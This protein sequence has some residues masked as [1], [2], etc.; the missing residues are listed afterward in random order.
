M[1]GR[2]EDCDYKLEHPSVSRMHALLAYDKKHGLTITDLGTAQG[3]FVKGERCRPYM[4]LSIKGG[5]T[6]TFGASNREHKIKLDRTKLI[7]R[8]QEK[9]R[10]LEAELA[11]TE[12]KSDDALEEELKAE[13]EREARPSQTVFV[14]NLNFETGEASIR[15]LFEGAGEIEE[16]RMPRH[17]DG[18]NV[19][20]SKG[21]C[22]VKFKNAE[23]AAKAVRAYNGDE[24]DDRSIK[25]TIAED[26]DNR[27]A[28]PAWLVN[29]RTGGK[30]KGGKGGKGKGGDSGTDFGRHGHEHRGSRRE[31]RRDERRRSRSRDRR[32]RSRDRRSRSRDRRSRSR[33]RRRDRSSDRRRSDRDRSRE[34]DRGGQAD[35]GD[36]DEFGR[37]RAAPRGRSASP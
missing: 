19:G 5:A 25:V 15:E 30:G 37:T 17:R 35:E 10:L 8:L 4:P 23:S 13:L 7:E 6:L 21:I 32:S 20:Q 3:S 33:D 28:P 18:D 14:G 12:G 31:S 36:M 26:D 29:S 1:F 34:R 9:A 11:R 27:R 24:L 22:F 16:I 2:V